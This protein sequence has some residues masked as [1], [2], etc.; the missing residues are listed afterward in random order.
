MNDG[1]SVLA[2]SGNDLFVGG[3][4]T[5][6]GGKVSGSVARAYLEW[7]YV[8]IVPSGSGLTLSWP[9][10]Y[11]NFA[12]Q[13]RSAANPNTWSNANYLLSTN[14][15]TK[16]ATALLTPTDQFFRLIGN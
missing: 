6:A 14:G 15:A 12:L 10:F 16:S 7:P 13:H 9:T 1:V 2:V 4:F 5:T 11:T 3:N 8:S